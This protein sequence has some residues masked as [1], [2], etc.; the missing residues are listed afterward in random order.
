MRRAAHPLR[1][2]LVGNWPPPWG[3][4]AVHVSGLA[5][6]LRARGLDVRVLDVGEGDHRGP[7]VRAAR[8]AVPFAVALAGAA[9]EG[10]LL[11]V[12]TNGAN[13]KSWLVALAGGRARR[14]QAPRGVLTLHSGL[15]PGYLAAS[16]GRRALARAACAGYGRILAVNRVIAAALAQAGV[17]PGRISVVPPFSPALLEV[18]DPP[19]ALR[20]FRTAWAPLFAAALAPG[21]VYG[22]DVLVPA[23]RAVRSSLPRAG[24]VVFGPGTAAEIAGEG[25]LALGA[26]SHGEALATIAAADVFVRPTRADGDALSVREALALGRVVVATAAGHRP[27]G[28][29]LA[30]PDDSASLAARMIEAASAPHARPPR[31]DGPDPFDLIAST[32]AAL[33]ASRPLPDGGRDEVRAPTF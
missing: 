18:G 9:A 28:C 20:S 3:G 33:A 24:L 5:R 2:A 23:F 27:M 32:Y 7:A 14:P 12:H 6:A 29:L 26:V 4:I 8:G 13:A 11:H 31:P 25:I 22:A 16:A 17:A 1:V 21:A 19:A 30:R 10:R 15:C